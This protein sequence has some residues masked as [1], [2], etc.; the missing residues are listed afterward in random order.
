MP[1]ARLQCG[2]KAA[3]L[4]GNSTLAEEPAKGCFRTLSQLMRAVRFLVFLFTI[5][6]LAGERYIV[7]FHDGPSLAQARDGIARD[8]VRR[9]FSRVFRGVAVELREGESIDAIARLPQVARVS[10]DTVVEA[11]DEGTSVAKRGPGGNAGG[12]GVVVAVIDSGIDYTHPALGGGIGPGKKVLGGYDFVNE[13]GDPMDDNR[14]GTHVA[15]I[16]AAH[17]AAV[18][19]LAPDVSLLAYKVLGADGKGRASDIIAGVERA[20]ADGA[21]VINLSLG[22]PGNPDDPIARAVESAVAQGVV[23]CVAAGNEG[24]FHAIGSPAGAASVIT[25]GAISVNYVAEFSSRGPAT[26]S[27]AIKPDLLA[28]GVSIVSTVPG[29]GTQALSGT[30]MA[31]PHVAALAALLLEE[32]PSWT[33]ARIKAALVATAVPIADTEV[34]TQ[35]TGLVDRTRALAN[36]LVASQTQLNFGLDGA[37]AGSWQQTRRLSIRNEGASPRTLRASAPGVSSAIAI[38]IVPAELTLAPGESRDLDVT[39]TVDN[40]ALGR[41]PTESLA[42]G[43]LLVLENDQETLRLPWAFLRAARATITY[44]ESFPQAMWRRLPDGYESFVPIHPNGIEILLRPGRYDFAVVGERD[45]DVRVFIVE[46]RLIDGDVRFSFTDADA[47]YAIRFDATTPIPMSEGAAYTVRTRLLFPDGSGS[48]VLPEIGGR[49]LHTSSFSERYG[50]LGTESFVEQDASAIIVAQHPPL[51]GLSSDVTLRLEAQDYRAQEVEIEFS[52]DAPMRDLIVM[53]RD[54][55]RRAEEFGAMPPSM[56]ISSPASTWKTTLYMTPEVHADFASGLQL[57]TIESEEDVGFR[58]MTTP[59][60]RRD[61]VGFFSVRGFVKPALPLY[62]ILD[63]PLRF[64]DGAFRPGP[65]FAASGSFFSGDVAF[66]GDRDESRRA[67]KLDTRYR[68]LNAAGTEIAS[69][70]V[71]ATSFLVPLPGRGRYRAEVSTQK[72][73]SAL[74]T[75]EFDTTYADVAPPTLTWLSIHDALGRRA[76]R[77][78]FNGNGTLVFAA[79]NGVGARTAVFFRR[80]GGSTWVQLTPVETGSDESAGTIFRVDLSDVLR[81]RGEIDLVIEIGDASGNTTTWRLDRALL[82]DAAKRRAVR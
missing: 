32:H 55:P 45:R 36:Q 10:R 46:D 60:I 75:M 11:F 15:G 64:G 2:D 3:S 79:Q 58:A 78:P 22:G 39:V 30:S 35:G 52:A 25:V 68:I 12:S 66:R 5:P 54:W 62:A 53:A 73:E 4:S 34:M 14:H 69:G 8:R 74:L 24:A 16:I 19:G 47:P 51:Q 13:D 71:G 1:G 33:P 61:E 77:L 29:G 31:T 44:D 38:Q 65:L 6:L 26:Q 67:T 80:T 41:P 70:A 9:E 49:S 56:R 59:M 17:S 57:S 48:V 82:S 76:R 50:I 40:D 43:G 28:P 27:G 81:V 7:E 63:E 20:I 23:V 18:N 72:G 21:D 37:V 42:F